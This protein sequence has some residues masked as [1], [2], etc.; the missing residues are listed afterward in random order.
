MISDEKIFKDILLFPT[1]FLLPWQPKLRVEFNLLNNFVRASPNTA[2]FNQD[3]LVFKG[4]KMFKKIV[5]DQL[6]MIVCLYVA[7]RC[8]NSIS[9]IQWQKF[10]NPCFLGYF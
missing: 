5:D 6:R 7:L 8:I 3:W 10:T 1:P 4:V 9:V 2:K